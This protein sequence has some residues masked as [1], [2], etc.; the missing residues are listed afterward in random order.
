[1]II[2]DLSF[3]EVTSSTD[4]LGGAHTDYD[5]NKYKKAKKYYYNKETYTANATNVSV[6]KINKSP[7]S[8][9]NVYQEAKAYAG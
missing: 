2:S 7:G 5:K 8:E 6:V 1:M 9:V 4:V 3:I